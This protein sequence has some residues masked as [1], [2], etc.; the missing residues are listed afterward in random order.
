[1]SWVGAF[2]F[3][4]MEYFGRQQQHTAS[5]IRVRESCPMMEDDSIQNQLKII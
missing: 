4:Y 1:M 2:D 3:V 5:K